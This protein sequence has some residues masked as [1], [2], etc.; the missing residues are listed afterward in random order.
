MQY[1]KTGIKDFNLAHIFECGQ[2]FRWERQN[3]G[4]YTGTAMGKIVNMRFEPEGTLTVDN[5]TEEEFMQIW[6]PYL[7]LERDKER[8][9]RRADSKGRGIRIW[10]SDSEAGFLG[11]AAVIHHIAE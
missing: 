6:T 8:F 9:E 7:D 10:D 5:C 2:C 3:D 1:T 4:S 11:N